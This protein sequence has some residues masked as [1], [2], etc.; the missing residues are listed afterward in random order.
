MLDSFCL[1]HRRL[2]LELKFGLGF[3]SNQVNAVLSRSDLEKVVH[4]KFHP[5]HRENQAADQGYKG[6]ENVGFLEA[7]KRR[8]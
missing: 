1:L 8:E 2:L 7:H 6:N 5:T 3:K 4:F